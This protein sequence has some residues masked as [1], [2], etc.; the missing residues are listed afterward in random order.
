M[1][2]VA[3]RMGTTGP[4]LLQER[5]PRGSARAGWVYTLCFPKPAVLTPLACAYAGG[6]GWRAQAPAPELGFPPRCRNS[7]L[8]A[9]SG[10]EGAVVGTASLWLIYVYTRS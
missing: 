4:G 1:S 3:S 6:T 5:K 2:A 8:T 7:V 10:G 9:Q